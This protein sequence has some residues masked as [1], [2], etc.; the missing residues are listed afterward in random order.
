V[1]IARTTLVQPPR[2][3]SEAPSLPHSEICGEITTRGSRDYTAHNLALRRNWMQVSFA[4][5][6]QPRAAVPTWFLHAGLPGC[7]RSFILL[8]RFK[9]DSGHKLVHSGAAI[10]HAQAHI[11][12]QPSSPLE[13]ARIS[14]ADEDQG[15][16]SGNFATARQ[17]PQARVGEARLP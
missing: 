3:R 8:L 9:R 14:Y 5:P 15:R 12:A 16:P 11:P 7:A 2:G 1:Q 13:D 17:G 6:G 10:F 4:R